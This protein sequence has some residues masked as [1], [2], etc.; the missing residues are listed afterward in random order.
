VRGTGRTGQS[1][2]AAERVVHAKEGDGN[3]SMHG[4]HGARSWLP[5]SSSSW[6]FAPDIRAVRRAKSTSS[7]M[8]CLPA[9]AAS[10]PRGC[11]VKDAG[12][13]GG[14][15]KCSA[16]KMRAR[17]GNTVVRAYSSSTNRTSSSGSTVSRI[18]MPAHTDGERAR[19]SRQT[20]GMSSIN[21]DEGRACA[22]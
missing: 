13:G 19:N 18:T 12:D 6:C 22:C 3:W 8:V 5:S 21:A 1:A 9:V 15:H 11:G 14:S 2:A 10:A 20:A 17:G 16:A 7:D 4:L